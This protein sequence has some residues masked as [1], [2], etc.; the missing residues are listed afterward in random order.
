MV[1]E[2]RAVSAWSLSKGG[3]GRGRQCVQ[4]GGRGCGLPVGGI[5]T[6]FYEL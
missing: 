1:P 6:R 3:W 2:G 4:Q 5:D